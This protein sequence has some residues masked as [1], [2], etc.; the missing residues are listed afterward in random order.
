MKNIWYHLARFC[1][2]RLGNSKRAIDWIMDR[3]SIEA[4]MIIDKVRNFTGG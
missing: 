1:L 4:R 3:G 2:R